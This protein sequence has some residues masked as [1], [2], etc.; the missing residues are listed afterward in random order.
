MMS[1][2][3]RVPA[4]GLIAALFVLAGCAA[5]ETYVPQEPAFYRD[6]GKPVQD[7]HLGQLL[8]FAV[9]ECGPINQAVFAWAQPLMDG[10]TAAVTWLGAT[11]TGPLPAAGS[12]IDTG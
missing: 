5:T 12:V 1:A 9:T 2:S 10:I 7:K 6:L 3:A 8:W 11:T 4:I